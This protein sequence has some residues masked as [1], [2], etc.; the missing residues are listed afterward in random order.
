MYNTAEEKR[1][2]TLFSNLSEAWNKGDGTL[3]ASY[4]ID[5]SD[6]CSQ[7]G[8]Q[9]ATGHPIA[10]NYQL[11]FDN[12]V[13][14]KSIVESKVCN[15]IFISSEIAIVQVTGDV[16]LEFPIKGTERGLSV[17]TN[18][19]VKRDGQWK[20]RA[21]DSCRLLKQGLIQRFFLEKIAPVA[22]LL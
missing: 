17:K 7:T 16:H 14:K 9:K 19:V 12:F 3:Y 18:I 4:F 8:R 5:D 22:P 20:V 6:C 13:M 11:L 10:A 2:L 15:I 21:Y 1:I